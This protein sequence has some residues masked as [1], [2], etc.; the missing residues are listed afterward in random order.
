MSSLLGQLDFIGAG[1]ATAGKLGA[2]ALTSSAQENALETQDQG[3]LAAQLAQERQALAR[4]QLKLETAGLNADSAAVTRS[5]TVANVA[6]L[7]ITARDLALLGLV[8]IAAFA[9]ARAL[10]RTR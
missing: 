3:A 8:A 10:G 9:L 7:A 5:A 2:Q 4:E 6:D 1:I